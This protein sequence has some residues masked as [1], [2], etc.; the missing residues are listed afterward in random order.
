MKIT[1]NK[2]GKKPIVLHLV[3]KG[4]HDMKVQYNIDGMHNPGTEIE[5]GGTIYFTRNHYSQ[6]YSLDMVVIE[7]GRLCLYF[8][9]GDDLPGN[10]VARRH[11][12][13]LYPRTGSVGMTIMQ[14]NQHENVSGDVVYDIVTSETDPATAK[15]RFRHRRYEAAIEWPRYGNLT[16]NV[17]PD[18]LTKQDFVCT[19][20]EYADD[21]ASIEV[22]SAK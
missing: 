18:Y 2:W 12:M 9:T 5:I 14:L 8:G 17:N 6:L 11:Y 22:F 10:L 7:G 3:R 13:K 1:S 4:G 16:V 19:L 21:N 20:D 15:P